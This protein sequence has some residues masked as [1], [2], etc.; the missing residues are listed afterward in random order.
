MILTAIDGGMPKSW[1]ELERAIGGTYGK[2]ITLRAND[3]EFNLENAL[4]VLDGFNTNEFIYQDKSDDYGH[5]DA[6]EIAMTVKKDGLYY[7]VNDTEAVYIS[8]IS[9]VPE[10]RTC[11]LDMVP[12][13]WAKCSPDAIVKGYKIVK[14]TEAWD[15]FKPGV[16]YK[17]NGIIYQL[18]R[19]TIWEKDPYLF[20]HYDKPRTTMFAKNKV[21][22]EVYF[23]LGDIKSANKSAMQVTKLTPTKILE[24]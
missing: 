5:L 12:D 13:T 23:R 1:D 7:P 22:I 9:D 8:D 21:A 15:V 16:T 10:L 2:E 20:V 14:T 11:R 18:D 19:E 3:I 4:S 24:D 17:D 6:D